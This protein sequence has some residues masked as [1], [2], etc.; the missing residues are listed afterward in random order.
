MTQRKGWGFMWGLV[1]V[2]VIT[3]LLMLGCN[4]SNDGPF[5]LGECRLNVADCRLQ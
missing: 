1:F 3:P 2:I 4:R 5:V